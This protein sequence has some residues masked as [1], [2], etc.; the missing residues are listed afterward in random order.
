MT[1][2]KLFKKNKM[3]KLNLLVLAFLAIFA[4]SCNSTTETADEVIEVEEE[5]VVVTEEKATSSSSVEVPTFE[6]EEFNT[7][8]NDMDALLSKTI[9]LLKAGDQEGVAGLESE[10]KALQE[11]GAALQDQIS[12]AD[13]ALFEA[14]MKEKGKELMSAAG[15][16]LSGNEME[17]EEND[18]SGHDH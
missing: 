7:F 1:F 4:I 15:L 2:K 5:V 8:A 3:K 16:N 18:H 9:A 14:Y 10:G 6:N 13:K 11:K 12:D 17:I